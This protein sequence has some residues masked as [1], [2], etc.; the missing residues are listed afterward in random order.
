M[1][2]KVKGRASGKLQTINVSA[3][4]LELSLLDFLHQHEIPIASSCSG[5]KQC[6]KCVDSSG[7]LTCE[8]K[9]ADYLDKTIEFDYL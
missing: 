3:F 9:V 7:A 4:E 8:L 6:R 5:K 1:Q 2:I